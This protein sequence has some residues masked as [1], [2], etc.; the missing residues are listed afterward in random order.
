MSVF[1]RTLRNVDENKA[2]KAMPSSHDVVHY[3]NVCHDCATETTWYLDSSLTHLLIY[4]FKPRSLTW[5][6]RNRKKESE[7]CYS[8]AQHW[9]TVILF[10][11][12]TFRQ[13][14]GGLVVFSRTLRSVVAR[15]L[16][17]DASF[18]WF[19]FINH[20][21]ERTEHNNRHLFLHFPSSCCLRRIAAKTSIRP[22]S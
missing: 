21:L 19:F 18:L 10:N 1:A 4:V 17:L 12:K 7:V 22:T 14:A 3:I 2:L 6:L 15:R 16:V 9:I 11:Q 8:W 13:R 20:R 5:W